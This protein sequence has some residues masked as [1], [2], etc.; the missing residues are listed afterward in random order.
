VYTYI[1]FQ[2]DQSEVF[3]TVMLRTPGSDRHLAS[4]L[5]RVIGCSGKCIFCVLARYSM[6]GS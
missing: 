6:F 1:V 5:F 3:I 4:F 2:I